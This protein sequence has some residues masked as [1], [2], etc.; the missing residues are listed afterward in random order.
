MLAVKK[1]QKLLATYNHGLKIAGVWQM[2][3][4]KL[5]KTIDEIGY[6]LDHEKATLVPKKKNSKNKV[7]AFEKF[8]SAKTAGVQARTGKDTETII[9]EEIDRQKKR[10]KA[11]EAK[12]K[13]KMD[14]LRQQRADILSGKARLS[15]KGEA[16]YRIKPN[17]KKK[18]VK[19]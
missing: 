19:K 2:N 4:E 16:V 3:R 18:A 8:Y 5:M 1:I 6:T 11:N 14:T 10:V 17:R 12:S 15:D 9:G 7:V 13:K